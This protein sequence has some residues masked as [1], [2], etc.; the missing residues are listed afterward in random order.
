MRSKAIRRHHEKRL[1]SKRSKYNTAGV[2]DKKAIG[3][4]YRTPALCGCWMCSSH[5]KVFGMSIKEV[6]DRQKFIDTE[7]LIETNHKFGLLKKPR[8]IDNGL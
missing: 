2:A 5:R 6:R 3:I 7:C 1:K 4:C 8:P